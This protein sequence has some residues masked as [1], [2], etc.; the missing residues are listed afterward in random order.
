MNTA[1]VMLKIQAGEIERL[2]LALRT[3]HDNAQANAGTLELMRRMV[4]IRRMASDALRID[5]R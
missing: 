5:D 2:T 4:E 3:I 1:E